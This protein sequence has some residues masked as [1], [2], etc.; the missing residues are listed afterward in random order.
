MKD[1]A[2]APKMRALGADTSRSHAANG[3]MVAM[4]D[5]CKLLHV[6]RCVMVHG[7][8]WCPWNAS[9][10]RPNTGVFALP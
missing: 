1:I 6:C 9:I 10:C 7:R 3:G 5:W 2:T 4:Q 8:S